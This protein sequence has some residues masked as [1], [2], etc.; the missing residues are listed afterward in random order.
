MEVRDGGDGADATA[1]GGQGGDGAR[2]SLFPVVAD[3]HR[4]GEGGD[5]EALAGFGGKGA[6]CCDEG[7]PGG[8]GGNGGDAIA[9]GGA[10]GQRGINDGKQGG[11]TSFGGNAGDGG[12]GTG[13]GTKGTPG[14]ATSDGDPAEENPGDGASDGLPCPEPEPFWADID[15]SKVEHAFGSVPFGTQVLP[16]VDA[17]TKEEL[18]TIPVATLGTAGNH[19]W[20]PNPFRVG[21]VGED[22]G[23]GFDIGAAV[24]ECAAASSAETV[25]GDHCSGLEIAAVTVC[26]VNTFGISPASALRLIQLSVPGDVLS[27]TEIEDPNANGG[28]HPIELVDGIARFDV[29]LTLESQAADIFRLRLLLMMP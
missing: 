29:R 8:N 1:T 5:A 17:T 13:P 7:G 19:F 23:F 25:A 18:G 14:T 11:A 20:A 21:F 15:L 6:R 26:L 27:V 22:N 4:K 12:D 3:S 10:Q 24:L 9:T 2:A 16:L 28:C